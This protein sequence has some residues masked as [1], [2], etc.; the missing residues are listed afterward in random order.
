MWK[1]IF[2]ISGLLAGSFIGLELFVWS[3][4]NSFDGGGIAGILLGLPIGALA[5]CA[6]GIVCGLRADRR[7]FSLAQL[8][9]RH[10][11][12]AV[13]IFAV[14]AIVIVWMSRIR[15]FYWTQT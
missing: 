13:V 4:Y 2:G 15:P 14:A 7:G 3:F 1:A 9:F 12:I 8:R 5:G 6:A 11:L 10:L